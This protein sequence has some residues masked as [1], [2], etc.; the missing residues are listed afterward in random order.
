[1]WMPVNDCCAPID[2]ATEA[3]GGIREDSLEEVLLKTAES[4]KEAEKNKPSSGNSTWT[5]M[6][7]TQEAKGGEGDQ[8]RIGP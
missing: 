3:K 7:E 2:E 5:R 1:M 4:H 8:K 6:D